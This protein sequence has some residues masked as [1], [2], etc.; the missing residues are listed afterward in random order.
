VNNMDF[1]DIMF[2]H[3]ED[4]MLLLAEEK[5]YEIISHASENWHSIFLLKDF[6][7]TLDLSYKF[8]IRFDY[9]ACL[10]I[11]KQ[12]LKCMINTMNAHKVDAYGFSFDIDGVNY[13]Y[14]LRR[15]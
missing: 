13:K 11:T 5:H 12:K 14:Y 3:E 15:Q 8:G 9:Y 4:L 1:F 2:Q 10:D 7:I 6:K